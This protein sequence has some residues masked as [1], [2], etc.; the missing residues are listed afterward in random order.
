[1]CGEDLGIP[2]V[3]P[4]TLCVGCLAPGNLEIGEFPPPTTPC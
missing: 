2:E 1:M 3:S 4:L